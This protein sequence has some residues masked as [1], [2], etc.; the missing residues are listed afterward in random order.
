MAECREYIAPMEPSSAP[1]KNTQQEQEA[2]PEGV[3]HLAQLPSP[4]LL[5]LAEAGAVAVLPISPIEEHGPHL[6]M[7]TDAINAEYFA[8]MAAGV[9][10]ERSAETPVVIA[11][12][13]PLGTH[14]YRFMGSIFIRQRV[15]RD[16][17]VD[18]GR[19][20]AAA[21]FRRF[22]IVSAHGGPKHM[23]ALDEAATLLTLRHRIRTINLTSTIIFR[24][25]RGDLVDRISAACKRPLTDEERDV[26]KMDYHAGWWETSMMLWL[27]PELVDSSYAELPE[28]L[29][30]IWK[31]RPASPL[32]PPA[33]QGYLGAPARG[34]TDFAKASVCVLREEATQVIED[35]LAGRSRPRRFR[36]P[37]Y[38]VPLFRTNRWWWLLALIGV[39][40]LVLRWVTS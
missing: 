11:P 22:L 16:L 3:Y 18:Y 35:F 12:L 2:M 40:L 5:E 9:I 38:R 10:R 39:V 23:V 4:R 34:D 33:G 21:G 6:P 7:G 26:F 8:K 37:L 36:S 29:I 32:K 1:E 28:A 15:I 30:P 17:V 14:V 25:L 20:L 24:F 27:R 19:S 31:A 13:V